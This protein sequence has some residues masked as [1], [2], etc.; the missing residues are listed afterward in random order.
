MVSNPRTG[1]ASVSPVSCGPRGESTHENDL[2]SAAF[3]MGVALALG[4][5]SALPIL[6]RHLTTSML[7][8]VRGRSTE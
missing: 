1:L 8:P 6:A 2:V 7:T 5:A 4:L 3:V